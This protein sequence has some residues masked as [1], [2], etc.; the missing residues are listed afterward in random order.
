MET[1]SDGGPA[2]PFILLQDDDDRA[3]ELRPH[4]FPGLPGQDQAETP[5]Y[6]PSPEKTP[7]AAALAD[8]SRRWCP[9][10]A[11]LWKFAAQFTQ[12]S[13]LASLVGLLV[14]LAPPVH[15][16]LVDLQHQ[17]DSA[18]LSWLFNGLYQVGQTAIPLN[19]IMLGATVCQGISSV[20]PGYRWAPNLAISFGKLVAMPA[21]CLLTV[22]ILH[23][24]IPVKKNASSALYFAMLIVTCTPTANNINVMAEVSKFLL[25]LERQETPA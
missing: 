7:Q 24:L 20:P 15:R 5:P 18:P 4:G 14:A 23:E 11:T 21:L 8:L 17:R 10:R 13:V 2:A 3:I 16:V 12:P 22:L 1:S 19:M 25:M 6:S 9:S